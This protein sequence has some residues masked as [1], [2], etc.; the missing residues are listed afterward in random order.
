MNEEWKPVIGHENLYEIS[1]LGR[2]RSWT[3]TGPGSIRRRSPKILQ[4]YRTGKK[5][6]QY[7]TVSMLNKNHKIH[8]L[9]AAAFFGPRPRGLAINHKDGNRENNVAEN[10]EYVTPSENTAHAYRLGLIL[11][12]RGEEN[13]NSVL[14]TA[15][16][17]GIRSRKTSGV[18]EARRYGVTRTLIGNIRKRRTW[19]HV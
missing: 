11:P 13:G 4:P 19:A 14:T 12:R 16:V 18:D 1:N 2:A 9:V 7:L 15:D 10:L 8:V 5:S 3:N 17:L 6:A